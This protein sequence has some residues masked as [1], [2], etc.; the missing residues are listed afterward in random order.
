[1]NKNVF[2]SSFGEERSRITKRSAVELAVLI[3]LVSS[4]NTVGAD[5][6]V[7]GTLSSTSCTSYDPL[8]RSCTG[9]NA[10]AYRTFAAAA[11]VATPGTTVIFRGGTYNER[12]RPA[13]SGTA[14]SS[15]TFKNFGTEA[16]FLT[17]SLG[18]GI[19]ISDRSYLI[20]DGLRVENRTW[21]EARNSHYI[22]LRN[23]IFRHNPNGGTTG[24]VR[25]IQSHYNQILDNTIEDGND[26]L[27]LIDSDYNVV[28]G[29]TITEGRHSVI[30]IRCGDYNI[31]R[32][33]YFANSQQKIGEVYDCG[34]DTSAVANSFNS[35]RHNI[36]EGNVFADAVTEDNPTTSNGNG[37]QYGGQEGIIRRNLFYSCY[38]GLAMQY[39]GDESLYVT[40]NRVY[41]NV[42]YDNDGAG[43][44]I[45]A[46]TVNNVY[47]NNILFANK[48]CYPDCTAVSPGQIVYRSPF[49]AGTRIDNNTIIYQSAGQPVMEL[50]GSA[51]R[52][53]AQFNSSFPG[54]LSG[55]LESNPLFVNAATKD[56]NVQAGSPMIDAGAFLT[57][58]SAAGSGTTIPVNDAHPFYDGFGIP[59]ETGDLIQ[60]QGQ[61]QTARVTAVN[62][63]TKRLTIDRSMTWSAGQGVSLQFTGTAPD[64]GA[65]ELVSSR[66]SPPR[67]L[68][69]VVP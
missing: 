58:T 34:A 69:I 8:L 16:V 10:T 29:N 52:T 22:I 12:L 6:Y 24:N 63:T 50:E 56:F 35:T 44:A 18:P 65:Y 36:F 5:I 55:N 40:N 13:M 45:R 1:M 54:V 21:L 53:L 42:F 7:D 49:P 23:C 48:G 64:I 61:T 4:I 57:T 46:N 39:Y 11:S 60:L 3:V 41:H 2:N 67:N 59:W 31:I 27:L 9:G 28:Q 38:V 30:G 15:V 43:I 62:Y 68:R 26:N 14:G 17:P 37:I 51:G 19:D 20:L 66:P 25:F 47:K 32:N 33:N